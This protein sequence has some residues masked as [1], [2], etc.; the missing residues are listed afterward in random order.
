MFI[1][2]AKRLR[3]PR[4]GKT[5]VY[6]GADRGSARRYVAYLGGFTQQGIESVHQRCRFWDRV[7]ERLHALSHRLTDEDR[8][9]IVAKL[10]TRVPVPTRQEHAQS[11]SPP[12]RPVNWDVM[13]VR[14]RHRN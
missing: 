3:G 13:Q 14:R 9:R 4:G 12:D 7:N 11:H 2:W 1:R 8:N 6:C 5:N 10:A